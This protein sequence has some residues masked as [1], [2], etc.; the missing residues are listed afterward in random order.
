MHEVDRIWL[1][2]Q[3]GRFLDRLESVDEVNRFA[4][5]F[6]RDVAQTLRLLTLMRNPDRNPLG[7]GLSD[8]PVVGLLT[9]VAKL[10]RLVC[11]F[12]ELGNSDYLHVFSR[13]LIESAI[14]ATYLLRAGDEAVQDF[15]RCSYKDTLRIL[16]DHK[17][18]SAFFRTAPGQRVLRSALDDLAL[19]DLSSESFA[20]QKRN[21]WRLQG[22]SLYDIFGEV[23]SPDEFP[24]VYGMFS[25]SVHGSWTES[26]DWSLYRNDNNTFGPYALFLGVDARAILP[27]VRY[28]TPPYALWVERIGLSDKSLRQTLL[29]I[30]NYSRTIYLRFDKLYDGPT[31]ESSARRPI[32]VN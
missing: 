5:T 28:A 12:Y 31:A 16:R 11:R 15:R 19:E 10:L 22:K 6:G 2:Y 26:M 29:R 4:L 32:Q 7:Y 1:K 27:L 3:E 13:P 17:S 9:R 25:E 20:Q 14:I 21:R 24:F 23:A 30:L 8:A 18:G